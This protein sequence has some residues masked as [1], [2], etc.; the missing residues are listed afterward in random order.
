[1][2]I[3]ICTYGITR[4]SGGVYF[5][6]KDLFTNPNFSL[7]DLHLYSYMPFEYT[8]DINSWGNI[9]ISLFKPNIFLYSKGIKNSIM[10][11]NSDILHM[12]TLWRYPQLIMRSWAKKCKG[13]IVCSPHGM[14]DP[15]IIKNQGFLK[16]IF[17]RVFMQ[18]S[19]ESVT[20]FHALCKKEFEDIRSYGLKQPIAII[21]NGINIPN[22]RNIKIE[23]RKDSKKHLLYLGRLHKKKGIDLLL[24][25]ISMLKKQNNQFLDN[26][27]LDV[28]GWDDEGFQKRLEE[29]VNNNNINDKVIF[30]GSLFGEEKNKIYL[31]SDAYIL[32][33]HGEG[34][35]MTILE[36]WSYGIPVLMTPQC[37]IPEGFNENAAIFIDNN[38]ESIVNGLVSLFKMN[39]DE[40]KEIGENGRNLVKNKFS[41]DTSAHKMIQLYEWLIGLS[42]KPDFVYL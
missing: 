28:V 24:E 27:I 38:I 9:P 30:H 42:N 33:S 40:L 12:E 14:L 31:N 10:K 32:P 15:Y 36:A 34:L 26:W 16:R 11:D 6:V 5:A 41:W 7:Q 22:C 39:D 29:I 21:P 25:A 18:K 4:K 1:M 37:N 35:P 3:A 23:K 8:D 20:C 2:K 17:A 19:L 13:P